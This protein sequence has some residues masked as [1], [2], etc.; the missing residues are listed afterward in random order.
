MYVESRL[1]TLRLCTIYASKDFRS[2]RETERCERGKPAPVLDELEP[3]AIGE[4]DDVSVVRERV[5]AVVLPVTT[6]GNPRS[7]GCIG[8]E[9]GARRTSYCVPPAPTSLYTQVTGA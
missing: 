8:G 7:G 6:V 3:E 1:R 5:A 9:N 4:G 2:G